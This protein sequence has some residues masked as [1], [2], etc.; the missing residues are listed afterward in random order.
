VAG[1]DIHRPDHFVP[2]A[3]LKYL[4]N[5]V[6]TGDIAREFTRAW[7]AIC[8]TSAWLILLNGIWQHVPDLHGE[9]LDTAR[10]ANVI[11]ADALSLKP[12][13]LTSRVPAPAH[14]V[15]VSPAREQPEWIRVEIRA[16]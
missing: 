13:D 6:R 2:I 14:L 5:P 9:I 11:I 8:A 12:G 16:M 10:K 3:G 7:P 1:V 4:E 15:T